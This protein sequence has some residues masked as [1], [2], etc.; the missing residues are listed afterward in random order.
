MIVLDPMGLSVAYRDNN[1]CS[2]ALVNSFL[3]P[4]DSGPSVVPVLADPPDPANP[5][6]YRGSAIVDSFARGNSFGMFGLGE[7]CATSGAKS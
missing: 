7:I 5:G 3:C 4:S 1:T 6:D 2:T